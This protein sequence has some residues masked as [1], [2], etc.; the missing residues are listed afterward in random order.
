MLVVMIERPSWRAS[1][2]LY[3]T[4]P[5]AA[6]GDYGDLVGLVAAVTIR[7]NGEW[8]K[9]RQ[10]PSAKLAPRR[11]PNSLDG[12]LTKSVGPGNGIEVRNGQRVAVAIVAEACSVLTR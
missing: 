4:E 2:N 1:Q 6:S 10:E 5:R 11:V 7:A 9:D 3:C 12:D 8:H